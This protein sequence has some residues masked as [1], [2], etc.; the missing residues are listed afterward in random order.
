MQEYQIR[1]AD[2]S[3]QDTAALSVVAEHLSE[4]LAFVAD[5]TAR[6]PV[7]L[8]RQGQRLGRLEL[9]EGEDGSFWKLG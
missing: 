4:V 2:G 8:W 3:S 9:I 1:L 7:E 6:E 5:H